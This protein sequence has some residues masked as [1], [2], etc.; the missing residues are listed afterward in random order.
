MDSDISSIE[1]SYARLLR[2]LE[3]QHQNQALE[4]HQLHQQELLQLQHQLELNGLAPAT[5]RSP[6]LTAANLTKLPQALPPSTPPS[7]DQRQTF[8][9]GTAT[10]TFSTPGNHTGSS[11]YHSPLQTPSTSTMSPARHDNQNLSASEREQI[12]ESLP[13]YRAIWPSPLRHTSGA[14]AATP[15][16]VVVR[17]SSPMRT[18]GVVEAEVPLLITRVYRYVMAGA[19]CTPQH[20]SRLKD[21]KTEWPEAHSARL[22]FPLSISSECSPRQRARL[23]PT[24]RAAPDENHPVQPKP[25]SG[26]SCKRAKTAA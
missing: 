24:R 22:F 9:A 10:S 6:L 8:A 25:A 4:Q 16:T 18:Y 14:T 11:K 26:S 3:Q 19:V 21:L 5:S 13:N 1:Q 17:Q 12:A 2:A 20:P 7:A 23:Q 15:S